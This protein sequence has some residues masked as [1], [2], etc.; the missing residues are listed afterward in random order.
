M[1]EFFGTLERIAADLYPWRW[2]ILAAIL[3]TGAAASYYAYRRGLH[4]MVWRRRKPAAI[5]A[6]PLLIVF[7]FL[8][9]GLGSP[10][11]IDETVE[12]EFPFAYTAVVPEGMEMEDVEM[13]MA[14]VAAMDDEPMME[15]MPEMM[16][17]EDDEE[18]EKA[19]KLKEGSF[20]DADSFHRGSGQA[21]IYRGPDGSHLLRLENLDVTNGP[22]LHVLLAVH[23]DPMEVSQIKD[24]GY[25]DL[26]RLKGNIGNQN[27][28]I[29]DDVNVDAQM[30]VI[31]YCKPFSVIFSVAPLL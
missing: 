20:R 22:R 5:I 12:E 23:P 14:V 13:T 28:H 25:H 30:S 21:I 31:I 29:P 3:V 17:E 24:N 4:L 6:T 7:G 10:L 2:L 19:V 26:G 11:F 8:A 1:A 9:W 16:M 15:A 18:E 27:Y